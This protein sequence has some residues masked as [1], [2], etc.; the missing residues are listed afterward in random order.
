MKNRITVILEE[1]ERI[2]NLI[3]QQ[4]QADAIQFFAILLNE[5]TIITEQLFSMKN[6]GILNNFNEQNY[7]KNLTEAMNALESGDVVLLA[8]ILKYDLTEQFEETMKQL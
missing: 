7:L 8:D 5:L 4:K 3:Y 2:S 1:I 6:Q